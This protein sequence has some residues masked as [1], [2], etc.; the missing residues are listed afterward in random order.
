MEYIEQIIVDG[1]VIGSTYALIALGF[2]LVFGVLG[3]LNVA[4]ADFYMLGAYI[5]LWVGTNAGAGGVVG[6]LAAVIAGA[7]AG[8]LLY[9]I[10]LARL[11]QQDMLAV[12]VA[13]LGI[14]Y[15]MENIVAR[16][17]GPDT[18]SSPPL[19]NSTYHTV[20]G[21]AISDAQILLLAATLAI[22]GGLG[23]WIR[24]TT[25]GRDMRAVAENAVLSRATGVNVPLVMMTTL[26][27]A[28]A[29]AA[30]GGILVTNVTETVSPFLANEVA[31]K[32]FVVTMVAGAGSVGGALVAGLGLGVVESFTVAY[33]GSS[34]QDAVGLVALVIV[35]LVRPRGLFGRAERIG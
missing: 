24:W 21:V 25:I 27:V 22:A 28:T 13:T 29:I 8:A 2:T 32:M 18:R 15:F 16:L 3:V 11:G 6:V 35:L 9:L 30:L 14:S 34:W 7:L 1:I 26:A 31:L 4:H 23:A 17:A 33:L 19:F 10:V 12:F 20:A 5:S